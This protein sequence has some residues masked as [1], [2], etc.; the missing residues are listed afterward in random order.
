MES[1]LKRATW[2][3]LFYDL[4]FVALVAQL[5]Y[6]AAK[7]HHTITDVLNIIVIAYTIFFTW[8]TTTVNRNLQATEDRFDQIAVQLKVAGAFVMS[9]AMAGVFEGEYAGYFVALGCIR[10][11]QVTLLFRLYALDREHAPKTYNI[12]TGILIAAGLWFVSGF[13]PAPYHF[14]IAAAALALDMLSPL[15]QG[16]GNAV[17]LLNVHHLQERLGLFLMLV[18]G[19][20]MLV[21]ALANTSAGASTALPHVVF[22]GLLITT[23]I[24]WLYFDYLEHCARGKRPRQLFWYLQ[25]HSFLF[26]SLIFVAAGYK[27]SIDGGSYDHN[28]VLLVA[29]GLAGVLLGLLAIRTALTA[30]PKTM[31]I[32]YVVAPAIIITCALVI[33]TAFTAFI[34]ITTTFIALG[35]LD[36]LL[37]RVHT[38]P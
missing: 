3:E 2:L 22:S 5:T 7:H 37:L 6:L 33:N 31:T 17:R 23:T 38:S 9:V 29:T 10:L 15:T 34:M 24:W 20:S 30:L 16:R 13:I 1:T 12:A 19:E 11:I 27:N 28:D 26:L 25:G 35:I 21:V 36:R 8:W 32:L 4:A 18:L 14:V